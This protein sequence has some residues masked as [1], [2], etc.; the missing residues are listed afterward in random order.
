MGRAR[1]KGSACALPWFRRR[2]LPAA[3]RGTSVYWVHTP[4]EASPPRRIVLFRID[5]AFATL[6][7]EPCCTLLHSTL[8]RT[9]APVSTS[10]P[11]P[12]LLGTVSIRPAPPVVVSHAVL[13]STRIPGA[14]LKATAPPALMNRL[15]RTTNWR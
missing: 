15:P 10:S 14:A 11:P 3:A 8:L 9:T 12:E 1:K 6:I 4:V 2:P 13:F 7:R 5:R